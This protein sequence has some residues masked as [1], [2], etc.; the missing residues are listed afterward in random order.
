MIGIYWMIYLPIQHP[1]YLAKNFSLAVSIYK[2]PFFLI[3]QISKDLPY[4]LTFWSSLKVTIYIRF[5]L[6]RYKKPNSH[7]WKLWNRTLRSVYCCT[8]SST[9]LKKDGDSFLIAI[10][11][12]DTS[13]HQQSMS[14]SNTIILN[15]FAGS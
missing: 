13:T 8:T 1:S 10:S 15:S 6:G 9:H 2:S 11:C 12:I 7:S 3:L 5:F 4:S 14:F